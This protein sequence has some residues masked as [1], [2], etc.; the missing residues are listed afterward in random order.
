MKPLPRTGLPL[1]QRIAQVLT[2][3]IAS[4]AWAAEGAV[5]T[6]QGLCREFGASR[7]TV[8]AALAQLKQAG[9]L[10]SRTG[11][12][13]RS[14]RPP[15]TRKLVRAEGDP[16]HAGI[17][18]RP[19]LETFGEL[20][21]PAEVAAYFGIAPGTPVFHFVRVHRLDGKPLS[22]VDSYLPAHLGRAFTRSEL[23]QP[24]HRLLW[25]R[26]GLRLH[27]SVHSLRVARAD[28]DV[29]RLLEIPLADPVLRIQSCVYLA[30]GSPIRWTEN[31]FREDRY[32][33]VAEME[34][35][36]PPAPETA[37]PRRPR[38]QALARTPTP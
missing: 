14:L 36:D 8:R 1:H 23:Q 34:W 9:L 7:S 21:C 38:T 17:A 10:E 25:E 4:G 19:H 5:T 6:E 26:H 35:P 3:R 22:V 2:A 33:Y 37:G 27:R 30:D 18:S 15:P 16:L 11:V 32:E 24:M 12:G 31:H 20:P 28:V 13:T 29:A